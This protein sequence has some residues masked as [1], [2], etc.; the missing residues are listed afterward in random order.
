MHDRLSVNSICFAGAGFRESGPILAGARR[1]SRE[2]GEPPVA[3]GGRRGCAGGAARLQ[4]PIG[5]HRAPISSRPAS[6][7]GA[8]LLA[9]RA[10]NARAP[11]RGCPHARGA[12]DLSAHRRSRHTHLGRGGRSVPRCGRALRREGAAGGDPSDGRECAAAACGPSHCAYPA[13][14]NHARGN[15]RRGGLHRVLRLLD[16]GEPQKSPSS[17]RC[18]VVMSCKSAT[19]CTAIGRCRRGRSQE[20]VRSR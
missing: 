7:C 13:R 4:L 17:V 10:R 18:R 14:C 1:A 12:L 6:R 5:N 2:R 16:G 8:E 19:M 15:R 20:T 9:R 11:D 3:R